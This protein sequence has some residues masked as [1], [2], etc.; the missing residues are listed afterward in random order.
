MLSKF[1][2]KLDGNKVYVLAGLGILY[3]IAGFFF[4]PVDTGNL[5]IPAM[6][7]NTTLTNI[8]QLGLL[9]AGRSAVSKVVKPSEPSAS[10]P[11]SN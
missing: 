5:H 10:A 4:G 8:W 3:S 2:G 11:S 6:D 9:I 1:Q 7:A